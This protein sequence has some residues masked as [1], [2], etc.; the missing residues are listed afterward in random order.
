MGLCCRA[1]GH[2][3]S[4]VTQWTLSRVQSASSTWVSALVGGVQA[5]CPCTTCYLG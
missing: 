1:S 3:E 2:G 4:M 5:G